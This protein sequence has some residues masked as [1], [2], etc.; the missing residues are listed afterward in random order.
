VKKITTIIPTYNRPNFLLRAINSAREQTWKDVVI[1]IRDNSTNDL[2]EKMVSDLINLDQ[3]IDYVRNNKNIG[4]YEN[5]KLGLQDIKTDF[6]SILSD[7]DYLNPNFY[8]EA[9]RLFEE[10]PQ[11]GFVAFRLNI[12]NA[13]GDILA[14]SPKCKERPTS[15]SRYYEVNEGVDEVLGANVASTWTSFVFRKEIAREIK[16]GDFS[17]IGYGADILF[18][19][20]AASRFSFVTSNLIGANFTAHSDSTSSTLVKPFDERFLYWWRNRMLLIKN[21]PLV[22]DVVKDKISKHY[23]T[24]STKSFNNFQYYFRSAVLLILDRVKKKQFEELKFDFIAMR[25][26]LPLIVLIGIKFTIIA[27]VYLKIDEKL[28]SLI[29]N[30]KV[31]IRSSV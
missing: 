6:F 10:Y 13:D 15:N 19:W 25:S 9:I 23:L 30:I 17:E 12:V 22:S 7:D 31:F 21:D 28:R 2:S 16:L 24:H 4:S 20:W 27:L 26:F 18:I 5:F 29:R 8:S 3:R 1:L 14:I 11:A